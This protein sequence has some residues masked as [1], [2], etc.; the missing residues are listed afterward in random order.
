MRLIKAK[1]DA[2][3]AQ[4]NQNYLHSRYSP[5]N[6]AERFFSKWESENP[7]KSSSV[8]ILLEP[9]L[10]YLLDIIRNKNLKNASIL[11]IFYSRETYSYCLNKGLLH[12]TAS[13]HPDSGVTLDHFL[14]EHLPETLSDNLLLMEWA[15][16]KSCFPSE[17]VSIRKDFMA[18]LRILQGN[19]ITTIKFGRKWFYNSVRNYLEQDFSLCL[20]KIQK[21]I[22]IV[23]SGYTLNTRL[24][25]IRSKKESYFIAAL[26][27][28]VKCLLNEGIVP[29]MIITTDPGYY[30]SLHYRSFPEESLIAAPLTISPPGFQR[31]MVGI[32]QNTWL[33]RLYNPQG[34]LFQLKS[35]EMGTVAATALKIMHDISGKNIYIAGLDLCY[36]GILE[37]AAPHEFDILSV[38]DSGRLEPELYR[39]MKRVQNQSVKY[40]NGYYF[41]RSLDTY[42]S[43]FSQNGK[44][45]RTFRLSGSPVSLPFQEIDELPVFE[46]RSGAGS[47]HTNPDYP[48][49]SRRK[50]IFAY[51]LKEWSEDLSQIR[52]T[53]RIS[54]ESPAGRIIFSVFT[55]KSLTSHGLDDT[56][57][58]MHEIFS[59]V[60]KL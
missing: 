8:I 28:S 6:E 54:P 33:D 47:V 39:R 50:E 55:G 37:H 11:V 48:D 9:G 53:K 3:T 13:W 17:S 35:P 14:A 7:I 46:N 31:N 51:M 10:G 60:G 5:L 19:T 2:D 12:G 56:I 45:Q 43:W 25:E 40:K 57:D 20:N 58:K 44:S 29:D 24:A 59:R 18:Y 30:A 32:D 26:P 52:R 22:L 42:S 36:K 4:C 23:A 16:G 34:N 21:N 1:D 38:L 41:T 15:P 27:S 49:Y